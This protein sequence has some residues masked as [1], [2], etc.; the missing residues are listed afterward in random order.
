MVKI[1][2]Y[3]NCIGGNSLAVYYRR[4]QKAATLFGQVIAIMQTVFV[5]PQYIR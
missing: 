4:R 1:T 3:V 5:E 2:Y